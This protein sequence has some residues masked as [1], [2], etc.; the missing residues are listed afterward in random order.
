MNETHFQLNKKY[1]QIITFFNQNYVVTNLALPFKS[2]RNRTK[3]DKHFLRILLPENVPG[4]KLQTY[5]CKPKNVTKLNRYFF[6]RNID[7]HEKI[8]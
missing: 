2:N 5:F 1:C 4:T 3:T 8:I 7:P 6:G